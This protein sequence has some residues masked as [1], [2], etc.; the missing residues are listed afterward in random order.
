M[1]DGGRT[2]IGDVAQ[3]AGVSVATVSR[4]L[5]DAPDVS[6]AT[7]RRVHKIVDELGFVPHTAARALSKG[8]S[9]TVTV[10]TTHASLYGFSEIISGVLESAEHAGLGVDIRLVPTAP[11]GPAEVRARLRDVLAPGSGPLVIIDFGPG[12]H[13]A[14]LGARPKSDI[15]T[16]VRSEEAAK[17]VREVL[18]DSPSLWLD[19]HIGMALATQHLL[20]LGHE[21]VHHVAVPAWAEPVRERGW[22]STLERE[23][24]PVPQPVVAGWDAASGYRAVGPLVT[25]PDVTAVLCGND[26]LAIGVTKAFEDAGRRV[27]V[28]VSIMGFDG[29]PEGAFLRPALSTVVMDW[30]GLGRRAGLEAA[31]LAGAAPTPDPGALE[32]DPAPH[33]PYLELRASTAAPPAR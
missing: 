10:V 3:A 8:R 22:R 24:R 25:D 1:N 13:H 21:T 6:A 28:D 15:V 5:N 14:V 31:T 18:P 32:Q 30:R 7:R 26:D 20:S 4:V 2:S 29:R 17:E 19:E 9:G 23:G 27:P 12:A 33:Q 11:P 16:L